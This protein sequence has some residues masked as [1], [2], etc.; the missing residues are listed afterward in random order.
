[1]IL[2]S[3]DKLKTLIDDLLR[4]S[5]SKILDKSSLFEVR[6]FLKDI[7]VCLFAGKATIS[8]QQFRFYIFQ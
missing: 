1:M 5:K 6:P 3:S 4:Y 7:R 2:T 8:L